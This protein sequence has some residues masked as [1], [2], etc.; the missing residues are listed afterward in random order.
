[1][2]SFVTVCVLLV[3]IGLFCG[4]LALAGIV[5]EFFNP[6]KEARRGY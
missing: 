6:N 2:A 1:M 5:A 3:F 4:A